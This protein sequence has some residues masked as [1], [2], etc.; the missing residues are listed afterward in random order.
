MKEIIITEEQVKYVGY[1]DM[2]IKVDEDLTITIK[3][4]VFKKMVVSVLRDYGI[5]KV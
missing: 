4:E 3:N 5:I 2:V 1:K